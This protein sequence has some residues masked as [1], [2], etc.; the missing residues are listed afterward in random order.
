MGDPPRGTLTGTA[1]R[2]HLRFRPSASAALLG[3]EL[4]T[5]SAAATRFASGFDHGTSFVRS[6]ERRPERT[7]TPL[8]GP[9]ARRPSRELGTAAVPTRRAPGTASGRHEGGADRWYGRGQH[10]ACCRRQTTH[11]SDRPRRLAARRCPGGFV[12]CRASIGSERWQRI[13]C[14]CDAPA[15]LDGT[16]ISVLE[17]PCVPAQDPTESIL[18]AAQRM[19]AKLRPT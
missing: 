17:I 13:A 1:D 18:F 7:N 4:R 11:T 6:S 12:Y 16:Q 19:A 9:A 10:G 15:E 14:G 8:T 5:N 2:L 3:C